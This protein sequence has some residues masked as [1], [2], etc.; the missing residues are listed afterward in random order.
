MDSKIYYQNYSKYYMDSN[1]AYEINPAYYPDESEE[2]LRKSRERLR[3]KEEKAYSRSKVFHRM[4]LVCAVAFV[5]LGS[6][7]TMV[8][9]ASIS[10]QKVTI[11]KLKSE[12]TEL[13]SNNKALQTEVLNQVSLENIEETAKT[14]LGM[15]QPQSYQIVYI[16]VPKQSYTV[17]YESAPEVQEASIDIFSQ[18]LSF[19]KKD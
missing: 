18:L 17:Q 12:L 9:Y 7:L 2:I 8:S 4:K 3:K 5:F 15:S 14:K 13:K 11:N 1:V 16:D 19:L 6:V 10:A